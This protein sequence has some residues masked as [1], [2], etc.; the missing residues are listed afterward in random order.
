MVSTS[1][2]VYY[3]FQ[4]AIPVIYD[5]FEVR[6][7]FL[8]GLAGMTIGGIVAGRLVDRNFAKV[9]RKNNIALDS[10]KAEDARYRHTIYFVAF[11]V[12]S[13][14]GSLSAA[15]STLLSHTAS[16]MLVDIFPNSSS[17]SYASGQVMRCGLSATSAA[18]LDP[19]THAVGRG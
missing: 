9:A 17:T 5:D 2:S 14:I 16:A 11:E 7:T 13:V 10:R 15:A 18:I 4:V 19:V 1:Y 12:V 6:L 8:P 3:T